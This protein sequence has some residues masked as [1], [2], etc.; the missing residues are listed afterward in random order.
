MVDQIRI[1]FL[2]T[3]T[4]MHRHLQLFILSGFVLRCAG[5]SPVIIDDTF[6]DPVTGTQIT[7]SPL[8]GDLH[9]QEGLNCILCRSRPDPSQTYLGD[10]HDS[11]MPV[12]LAATATVTFSGT[13]VAVYGV[14][15]KAD[16]IPRMELNHRSSNFKTEIHIVE[17]YGPVLS[18]FG[19]F[20]YHYLYLS[21][22]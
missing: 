16:Q 1:R 11:S 4:S 10:W 13:S 6:G 21:D 17:R 8:T 7:Y 5:V 20:T 18:R 12:N 22:P 9:W 14:I 3:S 19:C 2:P 15:D